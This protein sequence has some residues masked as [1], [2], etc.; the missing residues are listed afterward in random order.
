MCSIVVLIMLTSK[1]LMVKFFY[2]DPMS[3]YQMIFSLD[4]ELYHVVS[5]LNKCAGCAALNYYYFFPKMVSCHSPVGFVA[6]YFNVYWGLNSSQ[7]V[8]ITFQ[9]STSTLFCLVPILIY[10]LLI[11]VLCSFRFLHFTF[12]EWQAIMLQGTAILQLLS[13]LPELLLYVSL[14]LA[15]CILKRTILGT[16]C[17]AF[18][19]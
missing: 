7:F 18:E 2:S 4:L 6:G 17:S 13:M 10:I 11:L 15:W 3:S 14:P 1:Q 12:W 19:I 9:Q 8:N 16:H 5:F